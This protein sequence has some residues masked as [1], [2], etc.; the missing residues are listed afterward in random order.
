MLVSFYILSTKHDDD[1]S[2]KDWLR[3]C[4]GLRVELTNSYFTSFNKPTRFDSH[5]KCLTIEPRISVP[6]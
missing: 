2:V 6:D 3:L 1:K 4:N 5:L